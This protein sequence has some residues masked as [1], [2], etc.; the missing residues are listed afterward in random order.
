MDDQTVEFCARRE[1]EALFPEDYA[2]W[3]LGR[4]EAGMDSPSLRVLAGMSR[5]DPDEVRGVFDRAMKELGAG[6]IDLP[7]LLARYSVILARKTLAGAG[8]PGRP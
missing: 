7:E 8:I 3:A 4:L 5:E 6:G 1:L 2:D